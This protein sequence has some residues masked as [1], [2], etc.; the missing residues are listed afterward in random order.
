MSFHIVADSCCELTADMK[1]RGNIE[2]APLTLEV[3][4][5]S[6]LDHYNVQGIFSKTIR[7]V[8]EHT[9]C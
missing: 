2:I 9:R 6:I 7:T 4:G 8:A 3:G 5:E 1:K